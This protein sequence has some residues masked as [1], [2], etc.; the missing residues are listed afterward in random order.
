MPAANLLG[1]RGERFKLFQVRLGP[2]RMFACE[3]WLDELQRAFDLM[4]E[5]INFRKL[6]HGQRL[7]DKQLMRQ[8][9]YDSY[10]EIQT[11]RTAVFDAAEK[12]GRGEQARLEVSFAK[13]VTARALNTVLDRAIQ[14]HGA[15][16]VSD[17]TPLEAMYRKA[18]VM[19]IADGPDEVHIDRVGKIMLREYE[20]GSGWDFALR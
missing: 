14:V 1:K 4:C 2:A 17:D 3:R 6:A 8:H 11:A 7:A 18:R 10:Q 20:G 12:L 16:G 19:R 9:I 15:L 5:R 13:T